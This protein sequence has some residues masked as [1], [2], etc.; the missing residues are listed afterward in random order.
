[1]MRKECWAGLIAYNLVREAMRRCAKE[2][3]ES[4]ARISFQSVR[5]VLMTGLAALRAGG[6]GGKGRLKGCVLPKRRN[7][8][9]SEPRRVRTGARTFPPLRG[10]RSEARMREASQRLQTCAVDKSVKCP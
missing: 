8:R 9:P 3:E 5:R 2:L 1:M 4:V 10:T 7:K 6:R